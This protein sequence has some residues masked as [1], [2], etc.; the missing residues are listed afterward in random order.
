MLCFLAIGKQYKR[1]PGNGRQHDEANDEAEIASAYTC[2][3]QHD[4]RHQS[5]DDAMIDGLCIAH[6]GEG[7]DLLQNSGM[8]RRAGG[9]SFC[10]VVRF[11]ACTAGRGAAA[12]TVGSV[13]LLK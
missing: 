5:E 9:V 3:Q 8:G 2:Q 10:K 6:K 11:G 12:G 1:Y 7:I 4:Q 13:F